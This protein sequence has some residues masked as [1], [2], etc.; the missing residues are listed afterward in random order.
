MR[1]HRE[2][3]ESWKR[4][5]WVVQDTHGFE[6]QPQL[7]HFSRYFRQAL[8]RHEP[9]YRKSNMGECSP[10]LNGRNSALTTD[11]HKIV[12]IMCDRRGYGAFSDKVPDKSEVS[13]SPV[14][15]PFKDKNQ[16]QVVQ[17]EGGISDQ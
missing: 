8:L 6:C 12:C 17:N 5:V 1:Y 13:S 3:D 9:C 15:M 7:F 14:S 10:V 11:H 4:H 16:S 2:G